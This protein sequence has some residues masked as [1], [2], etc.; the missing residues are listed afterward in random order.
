MY[1][2]R[3]VLRPR[4][5]LSSDLFFVKYGLRLKKQLNIEH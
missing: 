2:I 4:K 1:P 5:H 3:Y